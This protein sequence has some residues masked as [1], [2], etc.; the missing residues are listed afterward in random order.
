[1]MVLFTLLFADGTPAEGSGTSID[2]YQIET[3][4]NLLW[5]STTQSVW[6]PSIY[7]LQTED[8]DASDTQNWNDGEGFSP[9]GY[10]ILGFYGNYNGDYHIIDNL[11]INRPNAEY[12]A[13]F[14]INEG[15]TIE[16]VGVTN[17][18][19]TGNEYTGALV[20]ILTYD[21]TISGC[22][23]TGIV[24][25]VR[26]VGGLVGFVHL[27]I[28]SENYAIVCV[29]GNELV[30]GL[31]GREYNSTI[32]ESYFDYET[33]LINDQH[34]IS[35]GALTNELFNNWIN[36]D[37]TLDITDYLS[38]DGDYYLINDFED[39]EKLLAFG[40][41]SEYHFLLTTD[42][43]LTNHQNFYIPYLK[44]SFNGD[45][46]IIDGLNVNSPTMW[47]I[48]LFGYTYETTIEALGATNVN[49]VGLY[50]V[51]G[52]IGNND[53]STVSKCFSTGSVSGDR[54]IG[55]LVGA[56]D[57][58]TISEC[59]ATSI[60]EGD[61]QVGGLQGVNFLS[62]LS[63]SYSTGSVYGVYDA[64]GLVGKN[65]NSDISNCYSSGSIDGVNIDRIGGLVGYN[66]S[67]ATIDN[68]I[69]NIENS[70]QANG[71]GPESEGTI[72]NLLAATTAEMQM[73]NTYT[74]IDWDFMGETI[75]GTEDIWDIDDIVNNGYPYISDM[76]WSLNDDIFA[77][78]T[79]SPT[80]GF[81][82]LT[83]NFTDESVTQSSTIVSWE[84]D[85]ENDGVIDSYEQNPAWIYS[86]PGIY[87]V[88]LTIFD[89]LNRNTSTIVKDDYIEV[90]DGGFVPE[91]NG[92]EADPYLIANLDNLFW[93]STS[94]AVWTSTNYFVQT[95][96]IDASDTQ[97]WNNGEGFSPIGSYPYYPFQGYYNGDNHTIDG[98]YIARR[99]FH[100]IALFGSTSGAVIESLGLTNIDV[101]GLLLVGGLVG[102]NDLN[103]TV[104]EC[105]TTGMI[106]GDSYV[107]G[108]A[109]WNNHNSSVIECYSE[110]NVSSVV[111]DAGGLVGINSYGSNISNSY[112]T[113][114]VYNDFQNVGGLVGYNL[115]NCSISESYSTGSVSGISSVGGFVGKNNAAQIDN[116]IWNTE[117]SGNIS[118]VGNNIGTVTNPLGKTTA[119]MQMM[120][121][122]T[123]IGWDFAGEIING[124]EDLWDI[125]SE[126]N[127][128][129]P[130]ILSTNGLNADFRA[131]PAYGI[132]PLTVDFIDE[133]NLQ[134]SAI[135]TWEWDFENDG[136]IDSY[137]QDPS[138]IY[139]E[140]GLYSVCLTVY[141][142]ITR[143]TSTLVKEDYIA[144]IDENF[145]PEGSGT[146]EDPY[147]IATL[148][149][150]SWLSAYQPAW[151]SSVYFLQ[152]QNIDATDTVNWHNGIGF[153]PIGLSSFNP[154]QGYYNGAN[155][156]IDGLFINRHEDSFIGLFG[157]TS[158]AVI[159]ALGV[160]NIEV[161]GIFSVG[162]LVGYTDE[163]S[164]SNCYSSGNVTGSSYVG[165]LVGQNFNYSTVT[166]CYS[167]CNVTG[168]NLDVGGLVGCNYE[169][170]SISNCYA[171]GSV[172]ENYYGTGGLVGYNYRYSSISKCF[173]TGMILGNTLGTGGLVGDNG[174]DSQIADCVWNTETS[175][176]T[177]GAGGVGGDIINL[178]GKTTVEMQMMST[179]TDIDWDFAGEI[180]NGTEDIWDIDSALNNCYPYISDLVWSLCDSLFAIF[181][182]TPTSGMLPL[183]VNFFDVSASGNPITS[184]QW[185]FENDGVIDSYEQNPTWVY[186]EPGL[187]SV[188]LTVS[189]DIERDTVTELKENYI[190]V[191][192]EINYGDIDNNAEVDSYDAA[193][194]LMYVVGLD[195]LPEDPVPWEAWRLLWADVDVNS[196][197][198]ALDAAYIL[199]YVVAIITEFP[200]TRISGNPE[201]AISLFNDSEYIYLNSNKQLIS[202]EYKI[203]RSRNLIAGNAETER[204]D[205]LYFQNKQHLALISAVGISGNI[206]KIPYER[207]GNTDCSLVFEF[208]CNGFIE[209]IDYTL[210]D[211]VPF[212][213]RLNSICPN[214]F[215]PVTNISFMIG[216]SGDIQMSIYNIKGQKVETLADGYYE[217]GEHTIIWDAEKQSSGVYFIYFN[218]GSLREVKKIT[219]LK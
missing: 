89:D 64:G 119:E 3:L 2:P 127:N 70:G 61:G 191:F 184:W 163:S 124:T 32:D 46:H 15:T 115:E 137:D 65:D 23:A 43:D 139:T 200:V 48:G 69:W 177:N 193:L 183:T 97:N 166:E 67:E 204:E 4:D 45:N 76:E 10:G 209:N 14:G 60:V 195:P 158:G 167:N 17:V 218:S 180:I 186:D 159:E 131:I 122:Y 63:K 110:C 162:G 169:Y 104:R 175:G 121:T 8:I 38:Y 157:S 173:T 31:V 103:S 208:E 13:L 170:S 92:T 81:S 111:F 134:S 197:V 86:E 212:I 146:E 54:Y 53:Y 77:G 179:F 11:Y 68:C 176:Q 108:V 178:L 30:G 210:T 74:D 26:N 135:I 156:V 161:A 29:N 5:L 6:D 91:G 72:T 98:L 16:A 116:C 66:I 154:F 136:I 95:Q 49:V 20:G 7:F 125:D 185:D 142:E 150:L 198:D 83:V 206:L 168:I 153:S 21:S 205:C 82:P 174:G 79:A 109:G 214:P 129:Y 126:L 33:V 12:V 107:G 190:E 140:P 37:M 27:S 47:K 149:N 42:I 213:T 39:F 138:W 25:G 106:D 120:S 85:F 19:I 78:L 1:M 181:A 34:L 165:G 18:N 217:T 118:G 87:S 202:L 203:S 192:S 40:Q 151:A 55:G 35:L 112:A 80:F 128:G 90:I 57:R 147:L 99:D 102:N 152:T 132:T 62:S 187:Y 194:L 58:S 41:N 160:T 71:V 84:W 52:L 56:N 117:T 171:T 44:G 105:Y 75:N 50:D 96:D 94:P 73:L 113:G 130:Y 51:G 155:H 196:E 211:P 215:N 114:D 199:Q 133:S 24:N 148:D 172:G 219:L 216:E 201:I 145:V 28:L 189:D 100:C 141:D 144:V 9:I 36:N 88:S 101:T 207:T 59:Y 22:Y 123:D 143:N 164:I 93:L 188:S 182:A